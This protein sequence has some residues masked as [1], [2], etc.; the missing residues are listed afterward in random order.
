MSELKRAARA[1]V[2]T[3]TERFESRH[4][5]AR[6][7]SRLEAAVAR[8]AG[9]GAT[10]FTPAWR[11][12]QGRAVLEARFAPPRRTLRLL[13]SISLAMALAVAASAWAIATQEGPAQFALPLFTV[14]AIL[15]LPFVALG[16]ASQRDA[17][18]ARLRRAIRVALLDEQERMPAPQRWED[19]EP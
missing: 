8:I 9:T 5:L 7:Q 4:D 12:E 19:E 13:N 3:R 1:L 10:V 15:A 18:E 16:M 17:A 6:S 11:E 14:L 2:E